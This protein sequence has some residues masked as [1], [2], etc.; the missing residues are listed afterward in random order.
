MVP[1]WK[2]M[3]SLMNRLMPGYLTCF[4]DLEPER[5]VQAVR[6][7]VVVQ[8]HDHQRQRREQNVQVRVNVDLPPPQAVCKEENQ[9]VADG[10]DHAQQDSVE[11]NVI[12]SDFLVDEDA[13]AVLGVEAPH[14]HRHAQQ[15]QAVLL[16]KD[17]PEVQLG[18]RLRAFLR[19][20]GAQAE[21]LL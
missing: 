18:A 14:H 21:D 9:H 13:N 3:T 11:V 5:L 6:Y 15:V 20:F 16:F 4:C 17:I 8:V 12:D 2:Q 1:Y 7:F 19:V 10:L